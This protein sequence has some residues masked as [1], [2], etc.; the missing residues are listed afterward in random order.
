MENGYEEEIAKL[1]KET[2]KIDFRIRTLRNDNE[3]LTAQNDKDI[4]EY[5]ED[6]KK[7]EFGLKEIFTKTGEE[8]VQTKMGYTTWRTMDVLFN[9]TD[10]AIEEIEKVYPKTAT[11]YIKTK[12]TL[13]KAPLKKDILDEKVTLTLESLRLKP[14]ERK[15]VYRYTGGN[16]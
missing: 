9:F 15:F 4:E 3:N 8:K 11:K 6:K 1:L 16:K 13:I 10:K 14:Q 5:Q 2:D 12:K 7:V